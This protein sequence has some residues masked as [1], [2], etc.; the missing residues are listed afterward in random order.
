MEKVEEFDKLIER[1]SICEKCINI[2]NKNGM[3]CSLINIYKNKAFSKNIPSIWTDWY[4][5]LD[6]NIMIIGQDWGPYN[7]MNK[8]Y[9]EY[10]KEKTEANWKRIIEQEKSMTKK[11]LERY[12]VQSAENNNIN[13]DK[14][15][16]DKIYIT[17]AIMCARK[18]ENYRGNNIRLK[19]S[20]FNCKDFIKEQIDIVK[21]KIILT[22]GYYPLYSLSKIYGFDIEKNL[23]QTIKNYE[24][25]ELDNYVIIPLYHPTAQISKEKQLE[26]YNKIWRQNDLFKDI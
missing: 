17:N 10:I 21:P 11:M 3:D 16:L 7:D 4:N 12:L 2:K 19:E 24:E 22:L 25:F 13:I 20:T 1:M 9:N 8:F 6:S 15:I 5:R 14:N 18:G 23:T 26:Q